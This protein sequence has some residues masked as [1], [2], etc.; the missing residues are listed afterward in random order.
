[1][2]PTAS[3][4]K[5]GKLHRYYVSKAI[6]IGQSDG[7]ALPRIPA[8]AIEGLIADRLAL[9]IVS[10]EFSWVRARALIK[11]II[12]RIDA[13]VIELAEGANM[14]SLTERLSPS[15]QFDDDAR[16]IIVPSRLGRRGGAMRLLDP[17]GRRVVDRPKPD[18]LW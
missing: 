11:R 8:K 9:L 15:D 6:L 1:M 2:S 17:T 12:I 3:R 5:A 18:P 7:G 16:A 10:E 14:A 13:I 4:G